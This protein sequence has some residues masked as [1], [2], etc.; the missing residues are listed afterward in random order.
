MSFKPPMD[1][2]AAIRNAVSNPK[3]KENVG[4]KGQASM[5]KGG[6]ASPARAIRN[7][8]SSPKQK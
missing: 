7:A 3:R 8:V 1:H 6:N 4:V 5:Q 2:P